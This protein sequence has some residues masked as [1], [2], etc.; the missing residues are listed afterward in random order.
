MGYMTGRL[1]SYSQTLATTTTS[2]AVG[3]D[4]SGRIKTETTGTLTKT[5]GY[6][7]A[8][9]LTTVTP[10]T[11]SATTYVYDKLGRRASA[12][13]GTAAATVNLFDAAS[14][15]TKTGTTVYAYDSAGRRTTE[16]AGTTVTAYA[17]DPQRT[18]RINNSWPIR[19]CC[20]SNDLTRV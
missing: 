15:L 10:S 9:Q 14:Q 12:K 8:D 5:Y 18:S 13:V 7:L 17:Y 6:D 11:G 16:T 4:P 2:T 1:S 20:D 19:W 3:Y